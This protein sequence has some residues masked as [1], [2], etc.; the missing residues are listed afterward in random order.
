MGRKK[1][2]DKTVESS[3]GMSGMLE[4]AA[5]AMRNDTFWFI[6]GAVL[7]VAALFSAIA[8]ASFVFT[9]GIDQSLTSS[10][11]GTASEAANSAGTLGAKLSE[12]IINGCF[13]LPS[14]LLLYF[15]FLLGCNLMKITRV[16][17]GRK[18]VSCMFL[19]A[20]LSILFSMI[21]MP[22]FKES[23]IVPGGNHGL[24]ALGWL[25]SNI[26]LPGTILALLLTMLIYC[27]WLTHR[28]IDWIRSRLTFKRNKITDTVTDITTEPGAATDND[29]VNGSNVADS[30]AFKTVKLPEEDVDSSETDD[31]KIPETVDETT[32]DVFEVVKKAKSTSNESRQNSGDDIKLEII[33][34]KNEETYE[35]EFPEPY[36]PRLDLSH[37]KF[38]TPDLLKQYEDKGPADNKDEQQAN[39]NRI[40]NVLRS[41]GIEITSISATPG[42]TVTLYEITPAEGIRISKIRNLEDDIALSLSAYGIRIIAP[43]PGKGTIGIEV[44]NANPVMVPMQSVIKSRKFVEST[45]EL[46]VALGKTITNELFM[47]DLAKMPHLLVAGAT[48]MGKSVGLNAI[49]TSLLY[50]KHPAEMKLVMVDP[51]MVEF[52]I[53]SSIEKHFLAKLPDANEAIITD[54]TK[55]VHTLKSLC[56]EMD[57]RYELLKEANVRSIIEY[58]R[59]F[60]A[61]K[62]NP[63]KGHRYLPYIVVVI[64]EFGDLIMTAG[65]EIET[66]ICRI[67]QKAR[68][69]GMHMIIA[70]QRP[71]TNIITGTIKANFPARIAFRVTSMID[72][73][74]ILDRPGAN[75]LI[76]R[77]D[78]LFSQGG[79]PER[80]QCAFVDTPEVQNICSYIQS[81]QGYVSAYEL[82]E[83]VDENESAGVGEELSRGELD[84]IFEDAA[85]LIVGSQQGS[86]S[87]IQRKFKIGYNRAGRIMDQLERAGIVS[88]QEG[89]KPRQVLCMDDMELD[90]KLQAML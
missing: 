26:G 54:P 57:N 18:F 11:S 37:Y 71:T 90:Q 8:C 25:D 74:T 67:A 31:E 69:V 77:G 23:F 55:V 22:L 88:A 68:A 5:N 66:P 3:N 60:I 20:W 44:P 19:T 38:P 51:K 87:L 6:T 85:R 45:Y 52:S 50:K 76:G 78:M 46:P 7:A 16:R 21:L 82:P 62:L 56:T 41:F 42:P 15:F 75:Q 43:I 70:T 12:W 72:S 24:N 73:R 64:D 83:Y 27:I 29:I 33:E 32:D 63:L 17:L 48:G 4:R 53:Y 39:K 61:R 59:L 28:T 80:V 86:T 10:V 40:I 36:N 14:F 47:F 30:S 9:G 1:I 2:S 13:G 84:P 58:N 34:T 49:V 65:K 35:G 89:S 81:Q 79:D